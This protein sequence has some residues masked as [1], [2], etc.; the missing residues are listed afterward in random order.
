M[1]IHPK[2]QFTG[3]QPARIPVTGYLTRGSRFVA[4]S[5]NERAPELQPLADK[6]IA[7]FG[8]GCLGAPSAIEFARAGALRLSLIDHDLVDP[9]TAVRWPRGLAVA[10]LPKVS[11]MADWIRQDYP[12][13]TAEPIRHRIGGVRRDVA[14]EPSDESILRNAIKNS[15]I[16]YDATAELGVQHFLS[17]LARHHHLPYVGVSGTYGA[18]GGKVFRVDPAREQGCWWCYRKA[19]AE[20]TIPEPP[21]DESGE[22]QPRGCADPTFTGANFDM[23]QIAMAGVRAVVSTLCASSPNGY[24]SMDWDVLHI[25]LRDAS[26][27]LIAPT[28]HTFN[29]LK[30][31]E[32]DECNGR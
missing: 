22:V 8:L 26:G 30:H 13:C 2:R 20:N 3:S 24:P 6:S 9:A 12:L 25:H 15:S 21:S 29:I 31:P 19:C 27:K 16:I 14:N 7:V 18:W 32:C 1:R 4:G 10:G 28:F 11:V 17:D 23:M 5:S